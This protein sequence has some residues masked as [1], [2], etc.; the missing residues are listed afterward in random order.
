MPR[1]A[2]LILITLALLGAPAA[3]AD[4][5]GTSVGGSATED[6]G[7][8]TVTD[9]GGGS[10]SGGSGGGG[11][12]SNP[13]VC[14]YYEVDGIGS[15]GAPAASLLPDVQ[16]W[17]RCTD[18]MTGEVASMDLVTGAAPNP[19]LVALDLAEQAYARLVVP[20]PDPVSNPPDGRAVVNIPVWFWVSDWTVRTESASAG[21]VTATVTASPLRTRWT[22][23]DGATLT[24]DG[25]GTAYDPARSPQVQHSDCTHTYSARS[26]GLTDTATTTWSVTYAATNGQSGDLGNVTRST[27]LPLDVRQ[28]VTNIRAA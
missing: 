27:N 18:T 25:P 17:R 2:L 16:Y 3:A 9:P 13:V 1:A 15:V 7:E 11:G 21:G 23:G 22:T 19:A 20:L 8:V 10:G 12:A 24:C 4:S 6:G 5:N 14:A 28:L 26:G